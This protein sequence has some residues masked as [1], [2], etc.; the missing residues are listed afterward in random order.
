[1]ILVSSSMSPVEMFGE[2]DVSFIT[3]F[4]SWPLISIFYLLVHVCK[5][6]YIF[7]MK[8]IIEHVVDYTEKE[9]DNKGHMFIDVWERSFLWRSSS[10]EWFCWG[11]MDELN[12]QQNVVFFW[13]HWIFAHCIPFEWVANANV[14][15][16]CFSRSGGQFTGRIS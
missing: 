2:M 16:S 1:M 11:W 12:E 15:M 4:Y 3:L 9:E 8:P 10:S 5:W 7:L 6:Q 14:I 13:V